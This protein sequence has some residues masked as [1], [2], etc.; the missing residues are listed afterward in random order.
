MT[1]RWILGCLIGVGALVAA[2]VPANAAFPGQPARVRF[3]RI[4]SDY[5]LFVMRSNGTAIRRVTTNT[6]HDADA[7]VSPDGSRIVFWRQPPGELDG[8]IYT[9]WSDGT[10]VR[11][12]TNNLGEDLVPN[13][14]PDGERIVFRS[15][16]QAQVDLYRMNADGTGV[17]R[18][19][20]SSARE[21]LPTWRSTRSGPTAPASRDSPRTTSRTT[22]SASSASSAAR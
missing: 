19:T 16:R 13:W 5:E 3:M 1:W 21:W 2:N 11:R 17:A 6:V 7:R 22:S 15:V 9:M 10:H 14:S 12:L 4:D 8:E 18:I 20:D